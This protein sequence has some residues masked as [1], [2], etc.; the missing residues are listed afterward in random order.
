[1]T[2][3]VEGVQE[4]VIEDIPRTIHE[5]AD[6]VGSSYGVLNLNMARIAKTKLN[7]VV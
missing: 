5:L 6:T 7:S 4:L 1:M 2:E 3:N